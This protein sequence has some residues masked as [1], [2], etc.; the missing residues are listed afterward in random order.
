[1]Y[2]RQV[3]ERL[4]IT[5]AGTVNIGN[6]LTQTSRLFTVETTH[7]SGG[8]VAYIGNNDGGNNYGGLVIS[9]GELDRECRLESAWGNSFF[10]FHTQ[11]D[12]VG[13]GERLRITPD[14]R[15]F[16]NSTVVTNTDDFLTI[17]RPAGNHNVTSMT[18]DATTATG[19]YANAL[20]FTKS[21]DYYYN[22]LVFTSSTGHQG[23][24]AAKMT[25]GGGSTPQ[26]EVRIGGSGL[27]SGDTLAMI[28]N[29]SGNV[30]INENLAVGGNHPWSVTG[31]NYWKYI[32]LW[33][34]CSKF[35]IF[36]LRKWCS[37]K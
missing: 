30:T 19:S 8:E 14:G 31:G 6:S 12:G 35:R 28:V 2:K 22:G 27:N 32:Y 20:I 29:A 34:R 13:A 10:T 16:V 3:G 33:W 36:K 9:A 15:V 23:G 5:S 24:I 17:K 37:S 18:V 4:R 25:S 7:A 11:S 21:K 1:M 26:I